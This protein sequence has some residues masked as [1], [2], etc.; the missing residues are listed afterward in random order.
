M[1]ELET[2]VGPLLQIFTRLAHHRD[3]SLACDV[4]S[5]LLALAQRRDAAIDLRLTAG[6]IVLEPNSLIGRP[7]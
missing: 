2:L 3:A 1:D 4:Q 5:R 6:A 7:R